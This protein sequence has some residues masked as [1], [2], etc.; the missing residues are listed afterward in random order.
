MEFGLPLLLV[1]DILP[2]YFNFLKLNLGYH[3][4]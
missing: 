4:E 2:D 3:C 1:Y